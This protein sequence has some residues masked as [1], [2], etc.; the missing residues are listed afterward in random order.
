MHTKDGIWMV[1]LP[2]GLAA[3]AAGLVCIAFRDCSHSGPPNDQTEGYVRAQT[4]GGEDIVGC[5]KRN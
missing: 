1:W 5:M 2:D 4:L 3:R